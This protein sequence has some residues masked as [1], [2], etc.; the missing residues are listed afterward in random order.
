PLVLTF[1]RRWDR[2]FGL[3]SLTATMLPYSGLMLVTGLLMT[4]LWAAFGWPLGGGVGV[5]YTLPTGP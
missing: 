4:M 3:G 5:E 1:A 2:E